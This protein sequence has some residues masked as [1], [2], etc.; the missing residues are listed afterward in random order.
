MARQTR[1]A[2]NGR[3]VRLADSIHNRAQEE[4]STLSCVM[5]SLAGLRVAILATNGFEQSELIEPRKALDEAGAKTTVLSSSEPGQIQ[6]MNHSEKGSRVAV[7]GE[8]RKASPEDFDAV[9]LPGGVGN[10]EK[11]RMDESPRKFIRAMDHTHC[12]IAVICHGPWLLISAGLVKGRHLTSYFTLQDDL[13]NAGARWS[14]EEVVRDKNWVSSRKPDD[15]PA[16]RQT[17]IQLF[18]E[19]LKSHRPSSTEK[20]WPQKKGATSGR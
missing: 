9:L 20:T 5:M 10:A 8:L 3:G 15:I 6:G 14:D 2:N 4:I 18:A 17:M 7:D 11:L 19:A 13:R 1:H 16:F 12:P